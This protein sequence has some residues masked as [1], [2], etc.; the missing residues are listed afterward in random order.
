[1]A[2]VA[3]AKLGAGKKHNTKGIHK[4]E[5]EE[6]SEDEL[7]EGD[8]SSLLEEDE[9]ESPALKLRLQKIASEEKQG[10]LRAMDGKK[11]RTCEIEEGETRTAG[12]DNYW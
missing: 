3:N 5:Q 12:C 11:S 6:A 10:K 4:L 7:E 1:M 8:E 9:E 2:A